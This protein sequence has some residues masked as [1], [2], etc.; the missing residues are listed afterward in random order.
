MLTVSQAAAILHVTPD[1]VRK[2]IA[3]GKLPATSFGKFYLVAEADLDTF[4][5]QRKPR[6]NHKEKLK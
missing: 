5:Q 3:S 1:A 4:Q 6:Q 2:W